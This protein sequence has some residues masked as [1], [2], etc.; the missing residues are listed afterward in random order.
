MCCVSIYGDNEEVISTEQQTDRVELK[1]QANYG[2][3][4]IDEQWSRRR[5]SMRVAAGEAKAM[6][7]SAWSDR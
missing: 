1:K 4:Q 6:S 3:L 2:M 5:V 7:T